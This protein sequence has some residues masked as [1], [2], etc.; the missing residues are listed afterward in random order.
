M[1]VV[2]NTF[3]ATLSQREQVATFANV[4]GMLRPGGRFVIEAFVPDVTRFV[5]GQ[6]CEVVTLDVDEVYLD[7]STY[8]PLTQRVNASHIRLRSGE[9]V[10]LWPVS[11]RFA[12]PSEL[13]L[14]AQLAG[15]DL[16]ARHGGWCGEPFTAA[17]GGH[18]SV[19]AKPR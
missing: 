12:W 7:V 4:A 14:M 15:L 16:E 10:E 9:P 3:F 2:F 18:V 17:S 11:L 6:R 19:W 8:D 13:D 5:R 1:F